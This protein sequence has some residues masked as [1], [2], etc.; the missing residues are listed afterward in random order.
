MIQIRAAVKAENDR[1]LAQPGHPMTSLCP[2]QHWELTG[3]GGEPNI[4]A[5]QG[6]TRS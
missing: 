5:E 4:T 1:D 2:L 6:R 3:I